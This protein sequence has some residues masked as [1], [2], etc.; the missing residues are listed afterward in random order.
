[1]NGTALAEGQSVVPDP[2]ADPCTTCRCVSG[3]TQ[4]TKRTCPVLA[5]P[6]NKALLKPGTCCPVCQGVR[7]EV[8]HQPGHPE[9]GRCN[10]GRKIYPSGATFRPDGCTNCTCQPDSTTLCYRSSGNCS[11]NS[12]GKM[13]A[14]LPGKIPKGNRYGRIQIQQQEAAAAS[15]PEQ[16]QMFLPQ[17]SQEI[18]PAQPLASG[19]G[20]QLLAPTALP[21]SRPLTCAYRGVTYQVC[22]FTIFQG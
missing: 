12:G 20:Q 4:C 11:S 2:I 6:P 19:P 17:M 14:L 1:M 22:L 9:A 21:A 10:V 18:P 3:S 7:N 15:T 8:V 13:L 16:Q 5:C